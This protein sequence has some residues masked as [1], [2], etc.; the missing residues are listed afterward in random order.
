MTAILGLNSQRFHAGIQ[1]SA[2]QTTMVGSTV[3]RK[4][5]S[6]R[7][8]RSRGD[9]VAIKANPMVQAAVE[10]KVKPQDMVVS[11]LTM[12]MSCCRHHRCCHQ[13]MVM[14]FCQVRQHSQCKVCLVYKLQIAQ[15]SHDLRSRWA[16]MALYH[17]HLE[18][19]YA[20]R[21]VLAQRR[22][23]SRLGGN[24]Q[25]ILVELDGCSCS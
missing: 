18:D 9:Q 13:P 15:L 17:Q 7:S 10:V 1:I 6:S 25:E 2:I 4:C 16:Q 12:M 5:R 11:L 20:D 23:E 19:Q 24:F 3:Q 14:K 21:R 22:P 8:S